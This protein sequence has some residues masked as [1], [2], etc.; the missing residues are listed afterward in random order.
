MKAPLIGCAVGIAISALFGFTA[1]RDSSAN[2]DYV[3][4]GCVRTVSYTK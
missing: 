1:F 3:N 4:Y 2:P